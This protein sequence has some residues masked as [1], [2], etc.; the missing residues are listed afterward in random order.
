MWEDVFRYGAG[1]GSLGWS[2]R[3]YLA[4]GNSLIPVG[5]ACWWLL[6]TVY[7]PRHGDVLGLLE[8]CLCG[9]PDIFTHILHHHKKLGH[10]SHRGQ[11]ES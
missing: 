9:L 6:P 1:D 4:K 10:Q 5:A 2:G 3:S 7:T 8:I 11:E